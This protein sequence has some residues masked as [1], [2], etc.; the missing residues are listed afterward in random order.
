MI[1][2]TGW[3][4]RKKLS[5]WVSIVHHVWNSKQN[6]WWPL[7]IKVDQVSVKELKPQVRT[8]N[9]V[10]QS[11]SNF[12][13]LFNALTACW[14]AWKL[15]QSCWMSPKLCILRATRLIQIKGETWVKLKHA[16]YLRLRYLS[17]TRVGTFSHY[18]PRP[19]KHA[20]K[21]CNTSLWTNQDF[22]FAA[23]HS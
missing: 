10:L 1:Y 15:L 7:R 20:T 6:Q 13:K 4:T 12:D 19:R 11:R 17:F 2:A 16:G 18:P 3:G 21:N 5:G 14:W 8:M 22:I 23:A 9:R